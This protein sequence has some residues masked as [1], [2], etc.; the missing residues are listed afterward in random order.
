MLNDHL[1]STCLML[2]LMF[3]LLKIYIVELPERLKKVT[4]FLGW[5]P[6][7][8]GKWDYWDHLFLYITEVLITPFKIIFD[9]LVDHIELQGL[10]SLH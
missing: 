9:G 5:M 4:V 8:Y 10:V 6:C 2:H 7:D 3:M 1:D